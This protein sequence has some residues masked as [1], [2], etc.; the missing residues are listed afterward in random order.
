[1]KN[2][3]FLITLFSCSVSISAQ[4]KGFA[5]IN[6]TK[7]YYET[8]GSGTPIIFLH[9]AYCDTRAWDYQFDEFAKDYQVIR[10]DL[11]GFGK[12]SIPDTTKPYQFVDDLKALM[13]Y[14]NIDK[15]VIVGHSMG[16]VPAFKMA[17]N[18][19]ER[20]LALVL[21]E[22]GPWYK[23]MFANEDATVLAELGRV[24]EIGKAVG[25]E[26]GKKAFLK[27]S[28]LEPAMKNP[29][30]KDI[31]VNMTM[32]YS[33]WNFINNDRW[34][35][36]PSLDLNEY[37]KMKT[38]TLICRGELSLP[39]YY[40]TMNEI[41]Q[42][43]PNSTLV[44]ISNSG[45]MIQ[46]ENP[47]EFNTVMKQF[48]DKES[49][50]EEIRQFMRTVNHDLETAN[51]EAYKKHFLNTDDLAVASQNQLITSYSAL[52][53]TIDTH[54]SVMQKQSIQPVDEKIFVID[55]EHAV[56]S[57]S[58][59]TTITFKN[60]AEFTMPYVWTLLIVK[61]EGEWKIAHVHN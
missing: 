40:R 26:A 57:T 59:V 48:L 31:L 29:L 24:T 18:Y 12:S 20:V 52:C 13:D 27:I 34:Q 2:L 41:N 3:I 14:L 33:G 25:I 23:G 49:V 30:A 1:M 43:L 8:L 44:E 47:K 11:R 50:K 38:P 16:G 19:P 28:I 45:H 6:N 42:I 39:F 55:H 21:L 35:S 9:G 51:A 22:G 54:L 53:D 15:A 4:Q 46:L 10:F 37:S 58:K 32:D 7:I 56:I 17:Y 36:G 60:G 61:R 5:D